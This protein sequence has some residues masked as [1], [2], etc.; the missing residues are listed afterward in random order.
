MRTELKK[1]HQR[2][3]TTIVYV[4]H[5]QIEAMTLGTHIAVLNQGAVQQFGTPDEIYNHPRD[6]FVASFVGSPAINLLGGEASGGR[7]VI[8]AGSAFHSG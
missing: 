6:T 7:A 5:D 3:G 2:L 4:T 1:L 8:T